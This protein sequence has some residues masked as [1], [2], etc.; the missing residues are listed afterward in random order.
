MRFRFWRKKES[1]DTNAETETPKKERFWKRWFRKREP[2]IPVEALRRDTAGAAHEPERTDKR[3]SVTTFATAP[4]IRSPEPPSLTETALQVGTDAAEAGGDIAEA[5]VDAAV[6]AADEAAGLVAEAFTENTAVTDERKN[7]APGA[8]RTEEIPAWAQ[9]TVSPE[10]VNIRTLPLNWEKLAELGRKLREFQYVVSGQIGGFDFTALKPPPEAQGFIP[11]I[12]SIVANR[13]NPGIP[14][15]RPTREQMQAARPWL[16]AVESFIGRFSERLARRFGKYVERRGEEIVTDIAERIIGFA[17]F[18]GTIENPKRQFLSECERVYRHLAERKT[19][20]GFWGEEKVPIEDKIAH[21]IRELQWAKRNPQALE[22]SSYWLNRQSVP[23]LLGLIEKLGVTIDSIDPDKAGIVG[24][25]FMAGLHAFLTHSGVSNLPPPPAAREVSIFDPGSWGRG[26]AEWFAPGTLAHVKREL[27]DILSLAYEAMP[28]S[29]LALRDKVYEIAE[30]ICVLHK[31]GM[32]PEEITRHMF[33]GMKTAT[34]A[35]RQKEP[36]ET[37]LF[38]NGVTTGVLAGA[39]VGG[40]A[41]YFGA[42][43]I[44]VYFGALLGGVV[45]LAIGAGIVLWHISRTERKK[46]K[47]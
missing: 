10:S 26:V 25:E 1:P 17:E 2:M 39:A 13:R 32:S 37:E 22:D 19:R 15:E 30:N 5:T 43:W 4:D 42:G 41:V 46:E 44:W 7:A 38:Q 27:P 33:P 16:K 12:A 23:L 34:S 36:P 47:A 45:G 35:G 21:F 6:A 31:Q 29:G 24:S 20:D 18:S 40:I 14:A 3:S 11:V 8:A 9:K 28:E